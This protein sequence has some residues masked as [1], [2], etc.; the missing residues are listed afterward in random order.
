[1][2]NDIDAGRS[3]RQALD[4]WKTRMR[5]GDVAELVFAINKGEELGTPLSAILMEQAE[6]M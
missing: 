2:L 1:M 4:E 6:K 3:R 5:D